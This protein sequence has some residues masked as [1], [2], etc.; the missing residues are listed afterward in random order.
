M[1]GSGWPRWKR[2]RSWVGKHGDDW[3]AETSRVNFFTATHS[4][5][6]PDGMGWDGRGET[7]SKSQVGEN[8]ATAAWGSSV[9]GVRK[10]QDEKAVSWWPFSTV[11]LF[12]Y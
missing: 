1:D 9:S 11:E 10:C 6:P 8:V 12:I 7:R 4:P 2:K 5:T 3:V